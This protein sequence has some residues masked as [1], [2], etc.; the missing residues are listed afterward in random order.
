[1]KQLRK[2]IEINEEL[3]DG[4][5]QCLP[6]CA[7]GSLAIVDGKAKL[8][9]EN[10]C[11]GLGAC[12]GVCPQGALQIIE[13]QADTFDEEAVEDHLQNR[14]ENPPI[15][16]PMAYSLCQAANAPNLFSTGDATLLRNWPVKLRLVPPTAPFLRNADLLVTA[17]CC[18][19]ACLDFHRNYLDGRVLVAGCPKFDDKE[20]QLQR[21]TEIFRDSALKSITLLIMDVPCCSAFVGIVREAQRAAGCAVATRVVTLSRQGTELAVPSTI[22]ASS[23]KN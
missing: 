5:G 9:A 2:I 16:P 14:R 13:R 3:C 17:D 23:S 21:L 6:N 1:M 22:G 20:G 4:C 15:N 12:L 7:E 8:V 10:L 11:D 18:P 19:I